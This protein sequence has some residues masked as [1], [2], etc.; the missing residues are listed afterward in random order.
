MRITQST[1]AYDLLYH[2]NASKEQINDL[3]TQLATGKRVNTVSDDPSAASSI[4]RISTALARNTQYQTNVSNAQS[5]L[6]TVSSTLDSVNDI[7]S[8]VQTILTSASDGTVST[9]TLS[10]Y[11][12]QV[13]GYL[14]ELVSLANTTFDGKAIFGG[15]VTTSDPYTL[16]STTSGGTTTTTVTYNGNSD[17]YSYPVSDGVTQ[18]VSI[19]GSE[20]FGG[21][22]LFDLLISIRDSLNGG[23]VPSSTVTSQLSSALDTVENSNSKVGA[24]IQSLDNTATYLSDQSTQLESLLSTQQDT[25]VA[26]ATI[27]LNQLETT[28][29]ASLSVAAE[30]LPLSLVDYL[31]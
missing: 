24:F 14:Q 19:S 12:S 11:G 1:I 9:S 28:L 13:D 18:Q 20:A 26:S 17:S 21:T 6:S 16:T 25:D 22:N 15:T 10:T 8:E 27:E 5:L 4:L 2:I 23:T 7:V 3:E 29:Q 30:V 31:S